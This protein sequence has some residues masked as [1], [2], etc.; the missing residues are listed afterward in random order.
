VIGPSAGGLRVAVAGATG[1]V[2]RAC[3][4]RLAGAAGVARVVALVRRPLG[5]IADPR[6]VVDMR[7]VDFERLDATGDALAV[8]AVICALG[9]TMKQAGSRERFRRVDHDY[10]VALGRAA[11][12]AGARHYLLV[13]ALG[14][15]PSAHVFYSR[16]KGET[17][18][19]VLRLPYR[20]VTVVRPSLLV[21]ERADPR[22]GESIGKR[23]AALIPGRYKP[24][25]AEA[26]AATLVD[27]AIAGAPGRRIIESREI[28]ARSSNDR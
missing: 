19:D 1:L 5:V 10:P 23:L 3:V 15:S 20:A 21:G 8:D 6:G 26:V 9:T 2:G 12:D 11:L 7:R 22:L 27:E 24:V 25:S 16:I 17:E 28:R 13:S 4:A 18:R 14:A